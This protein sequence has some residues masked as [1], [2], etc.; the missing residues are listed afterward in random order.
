[1]QRH[2][3]PAIFID[4]PT[5]ATP[6]I[7]PTNLARVSDALQ[8]NSDAPDTASRGT[9]DCTRDDG[10]ATS[11][12]TGHSEEATHLRGGAYVTPQLLRSSSAAPLTP[13]TRIYGLST[14]TSERNRRYTAIDDEAPHTGC[15]TRPQEERRCTRWRA[16]VID[17]W[18]TRD[19]AASAG[20]RGGALSGNA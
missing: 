17:G 15:A 2:A 6:E 4:T 20:T 19:N 12:Q 7:P 16:V 1:M 13:R 5:S 11:C 9:W 3:C 18:V 8:S 14:R 10:G